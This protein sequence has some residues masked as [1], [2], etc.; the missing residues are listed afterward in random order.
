MSPWICVQDWYANKNHHTMTSPRL[1]VPLLG[2]RMMYNR[3]G[4]HMTYRIIKTYI[5]YTPSCV[6]MDLCTRIHI[7]PCL[8]LTIDWYNQD[9]ELPLTPSCVSMDFCTGTGMR[10]KSVEY[11]SSLV[12]NWRTISPMVI[13]CP[14]PAF[15]SISCKTCHKHKTWWETGRK[16]MDFSDMGRKSMYSKTLIIWPV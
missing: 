13:L 15:T 11:H 5:P 8:T 12:R 4:N 7:V 16:S 6:S 1:I 10:G 3:T 9:L 14:P 2:P